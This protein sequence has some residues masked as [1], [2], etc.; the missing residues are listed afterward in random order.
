MAE[1]MATRKLHITDDVSDSSQFGRMSPITER[2]FRKSGD[3]SLLMVLDPDPE[4]AAQAT[5]TLLR[6]YL[7][8]K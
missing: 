4:K 1:F 3:K 5:R 2:I 8:N 7:R 6:E